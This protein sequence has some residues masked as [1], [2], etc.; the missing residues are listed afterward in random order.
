MKDTGQRK[1][2][3]A[4]EETRKRQKQSSSYANMEPLN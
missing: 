1:K 2:Q 4:E 3:H